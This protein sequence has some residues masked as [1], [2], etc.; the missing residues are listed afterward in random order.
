MQ[1]CWGCCFSSRLFCS[2]R[3]A[4]R[5]PPGRSGW[6]S[7]YYLLRAAPFP[8]WTPSARC[9]PQASAQAPRFS[10]LLF[11]WPPDSAHTS[12]P[13]LRLDW[14]L[15]WHSLCYCVR[16]I[17]ASII[18]LCLQADGS[19][20]DLP[21]SSA[22]LWLNWLWT[23][24]L[25]RLDPTRELFPRCLAFFSPWHWPTSSSPPPLSSP[26]GLKATIFW[27]WLQ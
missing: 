15:R 4:K 25:K 17:T 12:R 21:Y 19:A 16:L 13:P 27:S 3:F 1:R 11:W 14:H 20:G 26:V 22:G 7:V 23:T 10:C 18:R 8:T 6:F 2:F 5:L 9:L 24:T